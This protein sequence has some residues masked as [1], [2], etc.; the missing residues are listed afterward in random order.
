MRSLS[1]GTPA[2]RV[3]FGA[4]V[5]LQLLALYLPQAPSPGG[6]SVPGAD[7]A[8]HVLVFALVM[9]TGVLTGLPARWLALILA[10]HALLSEAIQHLWLPDRSGDLLDAVADVAG[11][12]LGWYVATVITRHRLTRSPEG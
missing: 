12:L 6:V 10:A 8:V 4:A 11:I 3:L 1:R 7:K 9:L 5:I 2:V